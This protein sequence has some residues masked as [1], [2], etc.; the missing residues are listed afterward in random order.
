MFVLLL[1]TIV[2]SFSFYIAIEAMKFGM[3]KKKWFVAGICLG[4]VA[5]PMFNVKRQ[6]HFRKLESEKG[7][8]LS[9]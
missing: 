1:M 6:M 9:F 8:S 7:G 3:C 4:P 2:V 5:W